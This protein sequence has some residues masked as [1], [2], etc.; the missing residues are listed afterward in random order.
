MIPGMPPPEAFDFEFRDEDLEPLRRFLADED[1]WWVPFDSDPGAE[2]VLAE[3]VVFLGAFE[4]AVKR[5]FAA[6]FTRAGIIRFVADLRI[7]LGGD[8]GELAPRTAELLM[9]SALGDVTMEEA[10]SITEDPEA[11]VHALLLVLGRLRDEC[12]TEPD[13]PDAF[14]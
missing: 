7:D 12:V 11:E 6:G 14:L 8:A 1:G 2:R 4:A 3:R 10:L 13:G 5:R 9:R